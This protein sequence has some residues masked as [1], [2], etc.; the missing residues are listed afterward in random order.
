MIN[1]RFKKLR[2]KFTGH[3]RKLWVI[4][5]RNNKIIIKYKIVVLRWSFLKYSLKEITKQHS[6]VDYIG[7][8]ISKLIFKGK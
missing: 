6:E 7:K 2:N 8:Y 1:I 5:F 3:N 4:H